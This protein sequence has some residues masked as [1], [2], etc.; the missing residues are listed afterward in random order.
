VSSSTRA[1]LS[2]AP[3]RARRAAPRASRREAVEPVGPVQRDARDAVRVLIENR[4][5]SCLPLDVHPV[6]H[7]AEAA[8]D[9]SRIGQGRV[10]GRIRAVP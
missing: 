9:V 2:A 3:W 5:V 4:F 1:V 6:L 10:G 7:D 8:C